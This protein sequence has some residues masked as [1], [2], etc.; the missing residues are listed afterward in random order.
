MRQPTQIALLAAAALGASA[1]VLVG[2]GCDARATPGNT[3]TT[4]TVP[5]PST[6]LPGG[7]SNID[8]EPT[9]IA[10]TVDGMSCQGCVD[11]VTTKV[12]QIEGVRECDVSLDDREAIVTVSDPTIA[13]V[14]LETIAKLG[15][16]VEEKPV[17]G[18]AE[19]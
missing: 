17:D 16:T 3:A 1:L 4:A 2:T 14:I 11:A 8:G 6:P 13:K 12:A 15:Y 9:K 10:F 18:S 7:A 5:G 19:S